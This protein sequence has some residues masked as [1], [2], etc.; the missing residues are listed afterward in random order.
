MARIS[1]VVVTEGSEQALLALSRSKERAEADRAR[2]VLLTLSGWSGAMIGDAFGV[3]ED[4]IRQWRSLFM[5]APVLRR[6]GAAD[7]QGAG[8]GAGEGTGSTGGCRGG[9]VGAGLR[10]RELDPAGSGRGDRAP[11]GGVD[12]ALPAVGGV[13]P[14]MGFCWRRARGFPPD[15]PDQGQRRFHCGP[16]ASRQALRTK[17]R[18][19]RP[20]RA[21]IPVV[22]VRDNG[23]VHISKASRAAL[24]ARSHWLTVEWRAKYAPERNPIEGV[25]RRCLGRSQNAPSGASH[26]HRCRPSRNRHPQRRQDPQNPEEK[27]SV[28]QSTNLGLGVLFRTIA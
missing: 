15:Q 6:V 9:S 14:K 11:H 7:A 12:P 25:Y 3:G 27:P 24:K 16:G 23:P 22:L 8:R 4:S 19:A 20:A 2:A 28:G 1:P 21:K 10:S 18:K 26:I 13:A 5:A 17:P